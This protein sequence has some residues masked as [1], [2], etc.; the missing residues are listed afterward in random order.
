MGGLGSV[1]FAPLV[2]EGRWLPGAHGRHR[3]SRARLPRLPVRGL[4]DRPRRLLRDGQR[5]GPRADPRRGALRR[6]RRRRAREHRGALPGDRR[7]AAGRARG[8]R[9]RA[10]RRRSRPT[11]R[12]CSRRRRASPAGSRSPRASSRPRCTSCTSSTS[13]SR[14][15]VSG[16]GTCPLPPVAQAPIRRRSGARTTRS[17][18]AA[19]SSSPST[20]PTTSSRR[21]S[22]RLPSSASRRPRRAVRQGPRG[23]GLGLLRDR[24][25]AVQ[26]GRG[27]PRER[28]ERTV[29][30]R[31]GRAAR[32][33][34]AVL[35]GMIVETV[36][37]TINPDGTVNC[38]AMGVE[39]GD[40]EIA[41]M[42]YRPTRTLRNLAGR[43]A[44]RSST[45]PTT[46][47]CSRRPRSRI[48]SRRPGRR[49]S[50]T[51]PCSPT[52]ARGARST[53]D[54][55]DAT[56][57][58]ARVTTRVVGRGSGREFIG[59]NRACHAVLEASIL[60]SRAR[61][62]PAG[63]DPRRAGAP[64][65][66]GGQDGRPARAGGDGL[67]PG[68]RARR[69][70]RRMTTV[71]VEAPARLHMGM[72]DASGDGPRRFGGLGWR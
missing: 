24:S 56:G 5:A 62:L 30:P 12:C 58:R 18:T 51:A 25:A 43:A 17:S 42:P 61:R 41:I 60:A 66:R 48:R 11:S 23:G 71:R 69:D 14:R 16:F 63:R 6:P 68:A 52:P 70:R 26:P 28:R 50:S 22:R 45:S 10:R 15:V 35:P 33:P 27:P 49:P 64:G 38:A 57:P 19:R 3:P 21:S 2:L 47:C 9:G 54:A 13:T 39:W 1:S 46:S 59:F 7:R 65:R 55:I 32:R 4:E 37:T 31:R 40:E 67:R 29:L 8:L 53:V 44:R 36:T 72:L 20:R 34:R